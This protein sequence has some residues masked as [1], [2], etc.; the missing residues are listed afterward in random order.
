VVHYGDKGTDNYGVEMF[1]R[2]SQAEARRAE[3]VK[4]GVE[5][6]QVLDKRTSRLRDM[7]P[8]TVMDELHS[9]VATRPG[10][11]T[12]RHTRSGHVRVDPDAAR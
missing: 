2:R 7:L 11:P 4:Q 9:A 12:S 10:S 3:L 6:S 5:P 1:D 8:T